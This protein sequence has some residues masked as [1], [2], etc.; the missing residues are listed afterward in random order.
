[1]K[2]GPGLQTQVVCIRWIQLEPVV[3]YQPL[4]TTTSNDARVEPWLLTHAP[5]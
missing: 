2:G 1:M 4:L 3:S 5:A